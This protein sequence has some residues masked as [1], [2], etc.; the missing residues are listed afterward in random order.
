MTTPVINFNNCNFTGNFIN[1]VNTPLPLTDDNSR[2]KINSFEVIGA[3]IQLKA[4]N[5]A[6]TNLLKPVIQF[7][8][9]SQC[10]LPQLDEQLSSSTLSL[11]MAMQNY[12]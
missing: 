2:V 9:F 6:V 8:F 4:Q 11:Q 1:Q 3:D 5:I 10:T 7:E 12:I